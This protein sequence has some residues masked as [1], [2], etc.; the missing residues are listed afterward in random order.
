MGATCRWLWG[1]DQ[2]LCQLQKGFNQVTAWKDVTA[3]NGKYMGVG[4]QKRPASVANVSL[5][6]CTKAMQRI[7]AE[8]FIGYQNRKKT[9]KS[10]CWE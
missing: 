8:T 2:Q 10:C 6:S 5:V 9:N 3:V 1:V 7:V 4:G